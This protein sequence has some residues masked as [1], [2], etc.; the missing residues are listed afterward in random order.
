MNIGSN[1]LAVKIVSTVSP[2]RYAVER[3]F[4]RIISKTGLEL[5][6]LE[7]FGFKAGDQE[8]LKILL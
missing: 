8:S 6:L 4:R 2:I 5:V 3:F 1:N 7:V